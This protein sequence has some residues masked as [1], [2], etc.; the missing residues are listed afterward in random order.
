MPRLSQ[1]AA[2]WI[3]MLIMAGYL[4]FYYF[5]EIYTSKF[6]SDWLALIGISFMSA[7]TLPVA[8]RAF[9]NGVSTDRDK[10][11]FSYWLIWTI[12]LAQRVW[13]ITLSSFGRPSSWVESPISGMLAMSL[14]IAAGFGA[15][16]PLT[17]EIPMRKKEMFIFVVAAG[18]SGVIAGI[19]IGVFLVAG[20]AD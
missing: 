10:F 20:W 13:I 3:S 1:F 2:I 5:T 15:S 9:K 6:L 7:S 4:I 16:A 11:I 18:F 17:G 12:V 19:A 14:A 8:W